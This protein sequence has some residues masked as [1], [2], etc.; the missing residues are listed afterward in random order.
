ME[1]ELSWREGMLIFDNDSL[2][3]V[4]SQINRYTPVKIEIRDPGIRGLKFGGYFKVGDVPAIL[5][6]MNQ[7]FG[8]RVDKINDR[9]V[10]LSRR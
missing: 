10:Y 4:V 5:T 2:E 3:E 1:K 6:T 8:L 7:D 9:L